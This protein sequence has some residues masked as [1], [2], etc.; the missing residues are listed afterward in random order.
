MKEDTEK[1]EPIVEAELVVPGKSERDTNASEAST[2]VPASLDDSTKAVEKKK[3]RKLIDDE[4]RA[5]GRVSRRIWELYARAAGGA[6]YWTVFPLVL[7]IATLGPVFE[8]GW[9]RL[10]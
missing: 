6:F 5:V 3:P 4:Q 2:I 1:T 7:A 8:N 9:L 10:V